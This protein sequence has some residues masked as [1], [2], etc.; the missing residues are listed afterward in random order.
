MTRRWLIIAGVLAFLAGAIVSFPARLVYHW[1]APPELALSGIQGTVWR[2]GAD[3]ANVAGVYLRDLTWETH[4]LAL[5]AGRAS[6]D[7]EAEPVSGFLEGRVS[8]T[9]GGAI[10]VRNLSAS[11]ALSAL[12]NVLNM[13]RLDGLASLQVDRLDIVDG[14]P[15]SAE[16]WIEVRNLLAPMIYSR[17]SIGGY[18]LEFFTQGDGVAASLEDKDDG[19]VDIAGGL[20]VSADRTYVFEG[21]L[22]AKANTDERLRN[23]MRFLGTP[24]SQGQY[25]LRLEGQL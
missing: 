6:V 16:G 8:A 4:P 10:S 22:A 17:G 21:K 24:N 1:F 9:A 18:R 2:G 7:I 11:M 13:P 3:H 25:D 12:D 5:F 14:L 15:V 20:V 23:Q 19:V